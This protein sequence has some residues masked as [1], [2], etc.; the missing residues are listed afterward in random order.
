MCKVC[1]KIQIYENND[2]EVFFCESCNLIEIKSKEYWHVTKI[3]VSEIEK[4][5]NDCAID[6]II[7]NYVSKTYNVIFDFNFQ[8]MCDEIGKWLNENC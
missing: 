1:S 2:H 5:L 3:K 8:I 4:L 7:Y 6:D